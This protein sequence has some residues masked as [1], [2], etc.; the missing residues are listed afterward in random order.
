MAFRFDFFRRPA[1]GL[2]LLEMALA[3]L[4]AVQGVRLFWAVLV[5]AGPFGAVTPPPVVKADFTILSR[6]DPFFRGLSEG[7]ASANA[8]GLVLY[9]VRTMADG[10]GAAILGRSDG[11]QEAFTVGQAVTPG[12]IL[13][14]VGDDHVVITRGGMR[15]RI[16]FQPPAPG[17]PAPPPAA[18]APPASQGGVIAPK[19]F[20]SA[21]SFEPQMRDGA[22]LGYAVSPRDGGQSLKAAGIKPGDIIRAIN[23]AALS[24]NRFA[25]IESEF[26]G[27][28]RIELTIERGGQ[29]ITKQL[30]VSP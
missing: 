26:A 13:A 25:E 9:G 30:Q 10:K 19:T 22:V 14:A 12:V 21:N 20:L 29:T 17:S 28:S 5:P 15:T 8:G 16:A 6:F 18:P 3:A 11:A 24:R 23:G 27:A 2:I 7:A 4:L 1:P